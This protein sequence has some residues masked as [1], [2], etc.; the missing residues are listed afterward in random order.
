MN[1]FFNPSKGKSY[2]IPIA[3]EIV[4]NSGETKDVTFLQQSIYYLSGVDKNDSENGVKI[5]CA[6]GDHVYEDGNMQALYNIINSTRIR[7]NMMRFTSSRN[8]LDDKLLS[9]R[10]SDPIGQSYE[11]C[12]NLADWLNPA[13]YHVN[14]VDVMMNL[15]LGAF[16]SLEITKIYPWE[17]FVAVFIPLESDAELVN[18]IISDF[19][20]KFRKQVRTLFLLSQ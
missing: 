17:R 7:I 1:H 13:D 14:S 2:S 9:C 3:I 15:V 8:T 18:S 6:F 16:T 11:R 19:E 10:W 20:F 5:R 12:I 4:N